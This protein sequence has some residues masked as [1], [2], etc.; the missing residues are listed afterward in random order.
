MS[1]N[2]SSSS[3]PPLRGRSINASCGVIG[4]REPQC[5]E[6]IDPPPQPSPQGADGEAERK[7]TIQTR[8]ARRAR[9][10]RARQAGRHDLDPCGQRGE[11]AV[12]GQA[13]RPRRHARSARLRLPADRAR[14]SDQ[15]RPLRHGR[16]QAL[17]LHRALGRGAR[18]RRRR[19]PRHANQRRAAVRPT[20]SAP[21]LPAF[22]GTIQQVPPRYS[23]I[24]IDGERAYD[25][26]RDG[27]IGRA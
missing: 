26:A 10:D 1:S 17:P 2:G 3:P 4:R 25:L 9:L 19:G 12:L 11:A 24:K 7:A 15:D 13:R 16:P 18:H 23:A 5:T 6:C 27:E 21:L 20:P 14:R 22:T 8:Q